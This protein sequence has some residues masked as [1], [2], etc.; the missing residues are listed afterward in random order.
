MGQSYSL[1]WLRSDLE[2]ALG[3]LDVDFGRLS[4]ILIFAHKYHDGQY[5]EHKGG[6]SKRVPYIT[7]P[8][9]VAK[10]CAQLWPLASLQDGL[11]DILAVA[12]T[13]D[14]LEDSAVSISEL[15]ASTSPRATQLVQVLTKPVATAYRDRN[16]RN[17]AFLKTILEAGASAKYV[18]ICDALHNLSRPENMPRTLLEKTIKK[19]KRDYLPFTFDPAFS[20]GI[21]NK[22]VDAI[23][24]AELALSLSGK[25]TRGFDA[26]EDYLAYSIE[27]ASGKI[28]EKHDLID[29]ILELRGIDLVHLGPL[30]EIEE[31][32]RNKWF[33]IEENRRSEQFFGKLTDNGE[34]VLSGKGFDHP[35]IRASGFQKLLF[36]PIEGPARDLMHRD[37][38]LLGVKSALAPSWITAASMRAVIAVLSERQRERDARELA[39][40]SDLVEKTG[41]RIDPRRAAELRLSQEQMHHLARLADAAAIETGAIIAA[42]RLIERDIFQVSGILLLE[43]RIKTAESAA[44]KFIERAQGDWLGLDD[45][46]GIRVVLINETAVR[47]FLDCFLSEVGDEDSV[48]NS[49]IGLIRDSISFGE[50]ESAIGY[51]AT[52]IRF[53]VQ[54]AIGGVGS[55]SC[56][57]QVRTI[58]QD[59]W[60]RLAHQLQYKTPDR[61]SRLVRDGLKALAQLRDQ[62]DSISDS[63]KR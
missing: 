29:I 35:S 53:H 57:L 49:D 42:V 30:S 10:I 18:K 46:I 1:N 23:E 12:L 63:L 26:I 55:V 25:E 32:V 37:F 24:R 15:E 59:A 52:H 2:K 60:A 31:Q 14:L 61:S 54:S 33:D 41:L 50:I 58:F 48:W 34:L 36:L 6:A 47:Q 44:T 13:H 5:R 20:D 43:H 51:K 17:E 9:G 16:E 11:E 39:D 28:L 27:R 7:H 21:R 22:F 4:K 45:I 40:Y 62:A 8:V 38:V 19:A 56:E 3:G